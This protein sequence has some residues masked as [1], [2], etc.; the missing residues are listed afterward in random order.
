MGLVIWIAIHVKDIPDLLH[1]MDDA[2]SCDMDSALVLYK[3]YAMH[4]PDKQAQLLLWDEIALPHEQ[5]KQ[6]FG[7]TLRIIGIDVDPHA[8]SITFPSDSKHDFGISHLSLLAPS[9]SPSMAVSPGWINWSLNV[10][11]L[12]RPM[13]Q[14]SYAKL[15]GKTIAQA[16]LYLNQAVIGDLTWLTDTIA[17]SDGLCLVN[18]LIWGCADA[19]LII[20]C[21]TSLE[22]MGFYV[23][24]LDHAFYSPITV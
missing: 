8:L 1:Y 23:P 13:L 21:H 11:T 7:R 6:S 9:H 16:S 5:P 10:F 19:N 18:S 24:V 20:Y 4:Y 14:S 15:E 2:W 22:G 3:P 17:V 12:L